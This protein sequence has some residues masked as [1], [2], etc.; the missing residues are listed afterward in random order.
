MDRLNLRR[1]RRP[2]V[3]L[4]FLVVAAAFFVLAAAI[5][6]AGWGWLRGPIIAALEQ[7][8]GLGEV[9]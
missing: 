2:G 4:T 3:R 1:V 9:R 7:E 5:A 6:L 8:T